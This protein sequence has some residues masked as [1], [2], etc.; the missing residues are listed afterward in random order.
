MQ[1]EKN[2]SGSNL[3]KALGVG[4]G[5]ALAG[6]LI[7]GFGL[8]PFIPVLQDT[9]WLATIITAVVYLCLI[10]GHVLVFGGWNGVRKRFDIGRTSRTYV[11]KAFLVWIG[12]WLLFVPVYFVLAPVFGGV[13][14]GID[15]IMKIGSLYGRLHDASPALLIVALI[16]PVLITPFAEELIFRG[17]LFGWLRGRWGVK[18]AIVASA[19]IFAAYHPMPILWP[20]VFLL[21][22]GAAWI[23]VKSQSLTPF[24]VIHILNSIAMITVAYFVSGW[25]I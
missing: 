10:L 5:L 9:S 2:V 16:Q 20:M 25:K 3:L 24:L 18:I 14:D 6:G 1:N 4:I 23:R 12:A 13:Q 8:R 21:G 11:F 17:S 7:I 22:L 15:G 19:A